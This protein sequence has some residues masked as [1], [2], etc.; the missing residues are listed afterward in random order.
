V[1]DDE[2]FEVGDILVVRDVG[3]VEGV[4]VVGWYDTMLILYI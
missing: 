3:L 2:V 1:H 4:L